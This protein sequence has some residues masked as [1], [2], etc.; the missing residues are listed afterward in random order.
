MEHS[1]IALLGL[2]LVYYSF[3]QG[4]WSE[5]WYSQLHLVSQSLRKV[6]REGKKEAA[7]P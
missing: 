5:V 7:L 4:L 3:R 1:N 2:K 6:L